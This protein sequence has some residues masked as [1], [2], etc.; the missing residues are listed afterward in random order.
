MSVSRFLFA[1]SLASLTLQ[2]SGP[3]D[4]IIT[5]RVYPPSRSNTTDDHIVAGYE[6]KESIS[7]WYGL[8][9]AELSDL[10]A[11]VDFNALQKGQTIKVTQPICTYYSH[12]PRRLGG[13]PFETFKSE[14][15]RSPYD[16]VQDPRPPGYLNWPICAVYVDPKLDYIL[17]TEIVGRSSLQPIADDYGIS[18]DELI[19]YN[20]D[21]RGTDITNRPA[22]A[23]IKVPDL[24]LQCLDSGGTYISRLS[25][26]S[27][28]NDF[29]LANGVPL[30]AL[31]LMN[32][33]VKDPNS[34][35]PVN[36]PICTQT[37]SCGSGNRHQWKSVSDRIKLL[38]Y[39]VDRILYI[40][41]TFSS[42]FRSN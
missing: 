37:L 13:T 30:A 19:R 36:W 15:N 41:L 16:D 23:S 7:E 3:G 38:A 9:L 42:Q 17:P 22:G 35:L 2:C 5:K 39:G 40:Q 6:T 20:L 8:T 14:N 29:A 4:C 34:I 1:L 26:A 10:N 11:G 24:Q 28:L 12:L 18:V 25:K 27:S 31:K 21:I 33:Y 32:R